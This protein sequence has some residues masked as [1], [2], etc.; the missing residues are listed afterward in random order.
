MI[1][2]HDHHLKDIVVCIYHVNSQSS[3]WRG[4]EEPPPTDCFFLQILGVGQRQTYLTH[5]EVCVITCYL[6]QMVYGIKC[7]TFIG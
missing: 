5:V 3:L 7:R 2:K 1:K 4:T 6:F